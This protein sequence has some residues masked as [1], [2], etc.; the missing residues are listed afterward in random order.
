M[1]SGAYFVY[2]GQFRHSMGVS[3]V[4]ISAIGDYYCWNSAGIE[5][6]IPKSIIITDEIDFAMT[7]Y[8]PDLISTF[9]SLRHRLPSLTLTT[10][11]REFTLQ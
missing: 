7:L 9:I 11:H 2:G 1:V 4:F 3:Q 6:F 10:L 8:V 5:I